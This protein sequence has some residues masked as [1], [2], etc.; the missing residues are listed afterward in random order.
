MINLADLSDI[1]RT[2]GPALGI[3]SGAHVTIAL[4]R[5]Y[6]RYKL[7][8]NEHPGKGFLERLPRC[9]ARRVLSPE[10]FAY[11]TLIGTLAATAYYVSMYARNF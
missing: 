7:T 5:A 8:E 6:V 11:A 2:A 4:T 1:I 10:T 3:Y 9:F